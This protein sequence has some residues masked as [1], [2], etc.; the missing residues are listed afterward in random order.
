[1]K[2]NFKINTLRGIFLCLQSNKLKLCHR[3][4]FSQ[5]RKIKNVCL[6]RRFKFVVE[7]TTN[8]KPFPVCL[9]RV[10][11]FFRSVFALIRPCFA[12]QKQDRPSLHYASKRQ[13]L[14]IC[15]LFE[16][17]SSSLCDPRSTG[18]TLQPAFA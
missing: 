6:K 12:S 16:F 18:G 5:T 14:S 17:K 13:T 2:V 1:M 4:V 10:R 8:L 11:L 7:K 9:E 3:T 15:S